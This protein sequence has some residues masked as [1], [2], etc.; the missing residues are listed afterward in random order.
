MDW[1]RWPNFSPEEFRCKHSGQLKMHAG[2]MDRLQRLRTEYG[3]PMRITSGYR[4][5]TH[6]IEARKAEPGAHNSGRA[7][8]IG[9]DGADALRILELAIKHGFTG[10]G[11]N[12]KGNGRF[13]HL[14]DLPASE[15]R[16]RPW[17]WSY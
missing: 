7:A 3:K 9:V 11:V 2:F 15:L 4:D 8:D 12:Q 5:A 14:D 17:I 1:S 16:P 13:I 6:P 10:I